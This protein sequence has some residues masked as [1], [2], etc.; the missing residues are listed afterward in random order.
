MIALYRMA[1]WCCLRRV[2]LVPWLLYSLNRM[3]SATVVPASAHL[4]R[5]VILGYRGLAIV[6]H[7]QAYLGDRMNVGPKVTIGGRAGI[8]AALRIED[9]A[10]L[11]SGAQVLGPIRIGRGAQI[12][13]NAL[14]QTDV[15]DGATKVGVPARIIQRQNRPS[16]ADAPESADHRHAR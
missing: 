10:L 4:G 7:R 6:I 1:N 9:D 5:D 8:P 11:G 16:G 12:G 15:P 2:P 14:V 13:S 3:L